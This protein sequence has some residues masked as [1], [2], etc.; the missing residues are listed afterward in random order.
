[1][2]RMVHFDPFA[3]FDEM[4]RG[5]MLRPVRLEAGPPQIRLDVA[6]N[7]N[8]YTVHAEI[9]G[10][11]KDDIHISVDG[12]LV[13]ISAE[14]HHE[15]ET[16]KGDRVIRSERHSGSL[17]RS[18][19]LAH[20]VDQAATQARYNDGVLEVTLPKLTRSRPSPIAIK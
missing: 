20:E 1:M 15:K 7:D 19:T 8:A 10:V 4:F 9:P 14:V 17:S 18:F 12:N 5:M 6:E 13:S 3:D 16:R 2:N 11:K